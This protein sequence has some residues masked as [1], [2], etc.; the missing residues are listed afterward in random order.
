MFIQLVLTVQLLRTRYIAKHF[1]YFNSFNLHNKPY[2]KYY[3]YF[4][5]RH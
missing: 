5:D 2:D 3:L 4:T 1:V